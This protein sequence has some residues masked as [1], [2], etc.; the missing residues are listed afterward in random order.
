MNGLVR[1]RFARPVLRQTLFPPPRTSM[2]HLNARSFESG[3][4]GRTQRCFS[5]SSTGAEK[6]ESPWKRLLGIVLFSSLGCFTAVLGY[7]QLERRQWKIDLIAERLAQLR[8]EPVPLLDAVRGGTVQEFLKVEC[9]GYF[10]YAR[11]FKIGARGPPPDTIEKDMHDS[12]GFNLVTPLRTEWGE[13]LVNRG[14][15]SRRKVDDSAWPEDKDA[16]KMV[17][18]VGVLT[19]GETPNAYM[20][21]LKPDLVKK[22]S[23]ICDL[24]VMEEVMQLKPIV[25]EGDYAMIEILELDESSSGLIRKPESAFS[26]F[27]STPMIHAIYSLTWFSLSAALFAGTAILFRRKP[28]A[29]KRGVLGQVSKSVKPKAQSRWDEY[30][31]RRAK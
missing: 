20:S 30:K 8:G 11:Q 1:I 10:D 9:T 17:H 2:V 25:A 23:V 14:W 3:M 12:A 16:E 24:S 28:G 27:H 26:N 7:W 22:Q 5:S 31:A 4:G 15:I 19:K 18:V 13:I 21:G 6:A 29:P